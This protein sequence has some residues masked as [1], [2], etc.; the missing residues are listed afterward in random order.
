[1]IYKCEVSYF[2]VGE[3]GFEPIEEE[4]TSLE[5]F[6]ISCGEYPCFEVLR[7]LVFGLSMLALGIRLVWFEILAIKLQ[8]LN[9]GDLELEMQVFLGLEKI[10]TMKLNC[11][12]LY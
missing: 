10:G 2:M 1:M 12:C 4:V 11:A 7:T 9:P 8:K 5:P 3:E 6:V